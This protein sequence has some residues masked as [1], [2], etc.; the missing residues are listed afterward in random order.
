MAAR[1]GAA[2][3]LPALASASIIDTGCGFFLFDTSVR[4]EL[5]LPVQGIQWL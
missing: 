4:A 5:Y 1:A 3:N 2:S